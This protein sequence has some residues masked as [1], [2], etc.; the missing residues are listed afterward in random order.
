MSRCERVDEVVRVGLNA[1]GVVILLAVVAYIGFLFYEAF[2][3]WT[4]EQVVVGVNHA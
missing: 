1:I 2:I 3:R 4:I